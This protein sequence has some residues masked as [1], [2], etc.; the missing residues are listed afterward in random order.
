MMTTDEE[1]EKQ[2]QE[3]LKNVNLTVIVNNEGYL[4]KNRLI[5]MCVR[6]TEYT[7]L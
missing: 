7:H 5:H 3:I 6:D 2:K 4:I 1:F